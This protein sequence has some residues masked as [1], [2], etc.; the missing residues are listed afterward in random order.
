MLQKFLK[1]IVSIIVGK[2][3]EDVVDLLDS[4]KHVNEFIIAKK[5]DITINQTR[6]ILY[7]IS[8]H[9]LISSIRKK[10]KRKGWYTYF[11]KIEV[12]KSL[13]FLKE[14]VVKRLGQVRSQVN[15]RETKEF[16]VCEQCNVEVNEETAL[17]REFICNECGEV[18]TIKDNSK[19]I[20]EFKREEDK[21]EKKLALI[22]EEIDNEQVKLD[23]K[24]ERELKKEAKEKAEKRKATAAKIKASKEKSKALKEKAKTELEEKENA[25]KKTTKKKVSEKKTVKK[26][27]S[28]KKVEKKSSKKTSGA[29]KVAAKKTSKKTKASKKK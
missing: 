16:Y 6:N 29:K 26:K 21:L 12:M 23:K 9:G 13:E 24:K 1:E 11:W 25:K 17:L 15:S 4:K 14:L 7:K 28:V 8:D 20:N 10:D 27:T 5:L 22:N 2:Q 19:L 3:S 18:F